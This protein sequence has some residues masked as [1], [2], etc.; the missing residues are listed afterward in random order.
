MI[1]KQSGYALDKQF[2]HGRMKMKK[3]DM[4]RFLNV[5]VFIGRSQLKVVPGYQGADKAVNKEEA[6]SLSN[7]YRRMSN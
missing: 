4:K 1:F 7:I 3:V 2:V 5:M 6:K